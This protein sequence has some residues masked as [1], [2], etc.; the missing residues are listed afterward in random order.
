MVNSRT[1]LAHFGLVSF[2]KPTIWVH[3]VTDVWIS[4]APGFY[5]FITFNDAVSVERVLEN[6][7]IVVYGQRYKHLVLAAYQ[8]LSTQGACGSEEAQEWN[9]RQQ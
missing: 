4:A 8:T 2:P 5:G 9:T 1:Y 7:P 6:T 3:Q